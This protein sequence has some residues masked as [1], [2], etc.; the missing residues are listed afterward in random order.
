MSATTF[1]RVAQNIAFTAG[2]TQAFDLSPSF[3]NKISGD[4]KF[5]HKGVD[6]DQTFVGVS[7]FNNSGGV[8]KYSVEDANVDLDTDANGTFTI[9]SL[10]GKFEESKQSINRLKIKM[11]SAG[12]AE[13]T[14]FNNR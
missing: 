12:R 6:V 7:I 3:G 1:K 5:Q 4:L 10:N 13:I 8:L 11:V 2:Q 9:P 14:L